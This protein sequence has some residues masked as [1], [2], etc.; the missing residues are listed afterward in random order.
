MFRTL[1]FIV[2]TATSQIAH[3]L[4]YVKEISKQEIQAEASA[5]MPYE[6]TKYFVNIKILN[7]EI[8]LLK[9]TDEI[10][11]QA[12]IEVNA[13][14]IIKGAGKVTINGTLDYDA[15]NGEFY[16]RNPSIM[17]LAIDEVTEKLT[18]EIKNIAQIILSSALITYPV[19]RFKDD[20][21][22]EKL[23]KSV[24]KSVKVKNE[25]LF[26]TLKM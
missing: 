10:S 11:L 2:L 19:Y 22:K 23:A 9:E 8:D 21:L 7:P 20:N 5:Y 25:K 24:L 26:I 16:I 12:N 1:L 3:T 13:P 4:E 6:I 17:S 14:G 15:I 18:S